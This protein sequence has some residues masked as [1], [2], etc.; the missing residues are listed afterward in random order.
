[1]A[2]TMGVVRE[3]YY[4]LFL[5]KC[6]WSVR[7]M[8][9]KYTSLTPFIATKFKLF[10]LAGRLRTRLT[11]ILWN[12]ERLVLFSGSMYRSTD[13]L[14]QLVQNFVLTSSADLSVMCLFQSGGHHSERGVVSASQLGL[15]DAVRHLPPCPC[16]RRRRRRG[17][18]APDRHVPTLEYR[19]DPPPPGATF[20]TVDVCPV[21]SEEVR[22]RF[23]LELDQLREGEVLP[24]G[25]ESGGERKG[26][27]REN[28]CSIVVSNWG[29]LLGSILA[30]PP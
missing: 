18:A 1:M 3:W 2:S 7:I 11:T 23:K 20:P 6:S 22:E 19:G 14:I 10:L 4:E 8:R 25:R 17:R 29:E 16:G 30:S 21:Q 26:V 15:P 5:R 9:V 12:E 24:G 13:A 28:L 27:V